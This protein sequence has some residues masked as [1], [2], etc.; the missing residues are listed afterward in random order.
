MFFI[1]FPVF[2][3]ERASCDAVTPFKPFLSG[4][5]FSF[6]EEGRRLLSPF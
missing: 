6:A 4:I 2:Y 5:C 1:R 3:V